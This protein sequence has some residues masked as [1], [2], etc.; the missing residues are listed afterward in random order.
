M[1]VSLMASWR[2][3]WC[4]STWRL[5]LMKGTCKEHSG[6]GHTHNAS[7]GHKAV[8]HDG[9]TDYLHDGHLHHI[10]DDHV[11]E[12]SISVGSSNPNTCTPDHD[13]K[14]HDRG[15]THG[16]KCGHE[17]APHGDH[18]DYLVGGHLHHSHSGHC[19]N[20]GPLKAVA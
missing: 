8:T 19:D 18:F 2:W 9:H 4:H 20:H 14:G 17:M 1:A 5:I 3:V 10:H 6:H 12:H 11:D 7:C 13:C 16:P 15:H